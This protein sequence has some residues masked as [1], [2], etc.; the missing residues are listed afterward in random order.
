[1][2]DHETPL[3][4]VDEGGASLRAA[5][6]RVIAERPARRGWSVPSRPRSDVNYRTGARQ[7]WEQTA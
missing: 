2:S 5:G 4:Q 3:A 6:W 1:M 7:L